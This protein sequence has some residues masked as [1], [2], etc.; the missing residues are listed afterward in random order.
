[1]TRPVSGQH[2]SSQTLEH[3]ECGKHGAHLS[4]YEEHP[5]AGGRKCEESKDHTYMTTYLRL[6]GGHNNPPE[7]Q[8]SEEEKGSPGPVG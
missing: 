3:L 6:P 2:S 7:I 4:Q 5:K 1:V 8:G